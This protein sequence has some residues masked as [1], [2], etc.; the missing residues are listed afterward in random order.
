MPYLKVTP[1][2]EAP[3][4]LLALG[5]VLGKKLYTSF[6]VLPSSR[7]LYITV[8]PFGFLSCMPGSA[9]HP[10]IISQL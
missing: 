7:L 8:L 1:C 6:Q 4:P 10:S 3:N 5:T 9:I 2:P